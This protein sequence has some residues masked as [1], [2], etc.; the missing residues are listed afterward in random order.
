MSVIKK[1]SER[2]SQSLDLTPEDWEKS[3]GLMSDFGSDFLSKLN[4]TPA[5]FGEKVLESGSIVPPEKPQSLERVLKDYARLALHSGIETT[6]GRFFGYIPGGGMPSA[7]LGDLLAALTNRYS[8][9]SG[10]SPGAVDIENQVL[11]W[12]RHLLDWPEESWGTLQSGGSMATLTALIAARTTREH[13]ERG[14]SSI[15]FSVEAHHCFKKA[16]IIAGLECAPLRAIASDKKGRMSVSALKKQ[17][18]MDRKDGFKPWIL[19]ATAGSTNLG[20]IDPLIELSNLCRN[21]KMWLHVDAAYGG[22]FWLTEEGKKRLNG[23]QLG[24]SIVLDP[25]KGLFQPYGLGIALVRNAS[26]LRKTLSSQ[27][28]YLQ[29][30]SEG[31]HGSPMEYSP[32]LTRHF[33]ALRLWVSL[34]HHGM[35]AFRAAIEE[36]LI[37]ASYLH[38]KLSENQKLYVFGDPEL[39]VVAFRMKGDKKADVNKKT[40]KLFSKILKKGRVHFSSTT[41]DGYMYLRACI[42]SFRTHLAEVDEAISEIDLALNTIYSRASQNRIIRKG[43]NRKPQRPQ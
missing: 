36:K 11:R 24:D 2:L 34:K 6:S 20:A 12:I 40:A 37:L 28:A 27:A 42:L 14:K 31:S 35:E 3:M 22:F 38:Q 4:T 39:S 33:R 23:M 21:E 13:K 8:G 9:V 16:L 15:Y 43:K 26:L 30:L 1:K 25:H 5:Y 19:C 32:E 7:A 29:D 41:I 18:G 17:I 10:V